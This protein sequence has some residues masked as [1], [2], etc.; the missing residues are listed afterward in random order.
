MKGW[1][2]GR[3][4]SRG[5]APANRTDESESHEGFPI[6]DSTGPRAGVGRGAE[7]SFNL[8]SCETE[9]IKF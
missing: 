8:S 1:P 2:V 7:A 5:E 4:G 6:Q 9:G 3:S